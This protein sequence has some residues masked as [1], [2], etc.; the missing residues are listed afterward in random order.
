MVVLVGCATTKTYDY[1]EYR[2]SLTGDLSFYSQYEIIYKTDNGKPIASPFLADSNRF[3]PKETIKL[4][5]GVAL[6]NPNLICFDVWLES[7][8]TRLDTK[9]TL[10]TARLIHMS[11][12]LPK[13]FISVDLPIH[14][15]NHKV[16]C[17]VIVVSGDTVLYESSK[18]R[19]K[20]R[21]VND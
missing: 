20:I 17:S 4:H 12:G 9:E 2:H 15:A 3:I 14:K 19:Y 21:E 7:L 8:F 13:E 11:E 6:Q 18:A 5:L 1:A 10:K 16:E